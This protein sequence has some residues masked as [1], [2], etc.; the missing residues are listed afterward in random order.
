LNIVKQ[1]KESLPSMFSPI[2]WCLWRAW[3]A[4]ISFSSKTV[5]W[6]YITYN[7]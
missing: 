4:S 5:P 3:N 7:L 1:R 6:D 2:R